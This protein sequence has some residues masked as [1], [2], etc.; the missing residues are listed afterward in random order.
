MYCYY[1]PRTF[2]PSTF[3]YYSC[4]VL[5]ASFNW[6]SSQSIDLTLNCQY[7][8]EVKIA[9]FVLLELLE[10]FSFIPAWREPVVLTW[11]LYLRALTW[12]SLLSINIGINI[13]AVFNW[14]FFYF[15][16][17]FFLQLNWNSIF[18]WTF[19]HELKIL[20]YNR[21]KTEVSATAIY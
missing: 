19:H 15:L 12:H 4:L 13:T 10:F 9:G 11:I 16:P 3:F 8:I 14:D 17:N 21:M 7:S 2:C 20:D 18:N 1:L 6:F 5:P